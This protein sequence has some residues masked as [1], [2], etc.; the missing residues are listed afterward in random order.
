MLLGPELITKHVVRSPQHRI[1]KDRILRTS[2]LPSDGLSAQREFHA[3]GGVEGAM[4]IHRQPAKQTQ[5]LIAIFAPLGK[6]Q[7]RL[8]SVA[9]PFAVA[10]GEHER[11]GK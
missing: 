10:F 4:K 7:R 11:Q 9:Y 5:L 6:A 1:G 2:S 3:A 8:K